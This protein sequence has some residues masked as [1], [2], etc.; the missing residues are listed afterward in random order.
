MYYSNGCGVFD[1]IYYVI[2][3]SSSI[4]PHF[5]GIVAIYQDCEMLATATDSRTGWGLI[6]HA[7]FRLRC[8]LAAQAGE[9][10]ARVLASWIA[11]AA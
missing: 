6:Q 7:W 11:I 8:G 10:I 5:Y 3:T 2:Q 9:E 4:H 1:S